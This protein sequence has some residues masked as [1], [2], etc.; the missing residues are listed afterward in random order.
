MS[1]T[2]DLRAGMPGILET[3]IPASLPVRLNL[4]FPRTGDL[5][6]RRIVFERRPL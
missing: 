4:D 1:E 5:T 3:V 2:L 6:V